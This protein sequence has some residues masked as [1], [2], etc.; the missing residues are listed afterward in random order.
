M[1]LAWST[2]VR[3]PGSSV[4]YGTGN[5][6]ALSQ[7]NTTFPSTSLDA[8]F[9]ELSA[10]LAT[11]QPEPSS[12][13]GDKQGQPVDYDFQVLL[14]A[15]RPEWF[16]LLQG[17]PAWSPA[18]SQHQQQHASTK[19]AWGLVHRMVP[20]GAGT[21]LSAAKTTPIQSQS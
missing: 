1:P 16:K 4:G 19:Y 10:V 21:C 8:K 6:A 18:P 11:Q 20:D 9:Q 15:R 2:S 17:V 12:S 3:R 13:S 5:T 7:D 14:A